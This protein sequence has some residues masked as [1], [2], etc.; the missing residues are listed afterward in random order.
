MHDVSE[1]EAVPAKLTEPPSLP[2][3]LMLKWRFVLV[4]P[5]VVYPTET[6]SFRIILPAMVLLSLPK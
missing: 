4:K 6:I 2:P 1:V 3:I 5:F